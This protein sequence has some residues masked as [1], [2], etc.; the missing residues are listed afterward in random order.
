MIK[1]GGGEG[2]VVGKWDFELGLFWR[3][4]MG[5]WCWIEEIHVWNKTVAR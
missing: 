3:M 1:K 5:R 2:E 4:G